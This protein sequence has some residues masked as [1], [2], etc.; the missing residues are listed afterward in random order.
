MQLI[1]TSRFQRAHSR[2]VAS[3]P[4]TER[5]SALVRRLA[6]AGGTISHPLLEQRQGGAD[7][8]LVITSNRGLCG[9]YNSAVL[10]AGVAHYR[11]LAA[12]G[13][14]VRLEVIGKKGLINV[15]FLRLPI[16]ES[17]TT[18]PDQPKFENAEQ[19]ADRYI[20]LFGRAKAV[21][22][23][24]VAYMRFVSAG[25]QR[26]TVAT[27]LPLGGLEGAESPPVAFAP[28]RSRPG[29]IPGFQGTRGEELFEYSPSPAGLLAELLPIA[30][31]VRL[32]QFMN[33][34]VVSEQVARMTAMK[35]ATENA[36]DMIQRLTQQYNRA[37]QAQIT[38]ELAEIVG[39]ADALK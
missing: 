16:D 8:L 33:D 7:L 20:D 12:A 13:R 15:R 2:A 24:H 6:A 5:V 21:D 34:A 10:R 9:G 27:L 19:L 17:Y 29:D 32:F 28:G 31:K 3:K 36:A 26:A 39:G 22:S 14:Q 25:V 38:K 18:F 35:A 23:V 30:V 1:A 11:A 37:R 4:Y